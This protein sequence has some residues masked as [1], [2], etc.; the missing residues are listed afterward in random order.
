MSTRHWVYVLRVVPA[1]GLP[2]P[3]YLRGKATV[4]ALPIL[5]VITPLPVWS[6]TK[7]ARDLREGPVATRAQDTGSPALVLRHTHR[8]LGSPW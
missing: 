5:V 1:A 2:L 8:T 3:R 7:V 4:V 6:V